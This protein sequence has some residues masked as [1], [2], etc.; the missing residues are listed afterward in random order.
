MSILYNKTATLYT[1]SRNTTTKVA[2]Y[3]T[4]WT[5]F[6]CNIQPVNTKDGIDW[7]DFL[8][9]KKLYSDKQLNVWDKVVCDWITYIVERTEHRDGL[10]RKF[11]KSFIN[12]SNWN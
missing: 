3:S 9:T 2:S 5:S 4:T 8:K 12:E 7:V 10:K 6:A 11:F 1:Y